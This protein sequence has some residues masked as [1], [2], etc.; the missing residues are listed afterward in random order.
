MRLTNAIVSLIVNS[1][2]PDWQWSWVVSGPVRFA[3]DAR[4]AEMME[5]SQKP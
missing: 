5:K 4:L 2:H 3:F 1:H